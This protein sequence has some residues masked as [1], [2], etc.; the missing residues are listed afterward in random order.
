MNIRTLVEILLPL[1]V[2]LVVS[3][4]AKGLATDKCTDARLKDQIKKQAKCL[5]PLVNQYV[6]G[7]LK[8]YKKQKSKNTKIFYLAYACKTHTKL[9][10]KVKK[11]N[12]QFATKCLDSK[13]VQLA[14][15]AHSLL[16]LRCNSSDIV[17]MIDANK[18]NKFPRL[19]EQIIGSDAMSYFKSLVK[20][21]KTCNTF[22]MGDEFRYING[23]CFNGIIQA[24]NRPIG[25]YFYDK[26]LAFPEYISP[27]KSITSS[28]KSCLDENTCFSQKEMNLA[29]AG[30][31]TV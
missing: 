28:L 24:F 9:W 3:Q 12:N 14:N 29:R 6:K 13:M 16:E 1:F 2:L 17:G 26:N 4:H 15:A 19:A 20:F 18:F 22:E 11:C 21:D 30:S 10:K 27:C 8:V 7:V 25:M 31:S 5:Y 23:P